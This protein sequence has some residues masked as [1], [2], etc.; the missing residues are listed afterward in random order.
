MKC[1]KESFKY[2]FGR[3]FFGTVGI[4]CNF[5]GVDHLNIADASMLNKLSPFFAIIFSFFILKE[6]V[7]NY[8]IGC[9]L[10]AIIGA[11]FILKPSGSAMLSVPA[12]IAMVG[13]MGAG[14]A[15]TLLRK[16]TGM[17][18]KGPFIVFFFSVFSCLC[19]LPYCIFNYTHMEPIQCFYLFMTGVAATFGQFF[20]TAA[21]SHAPAKELSVYDYSNVIFAG[22]LGFIILGE[23]PDVFS[24]IGC[25]LIISP[26]VIMFIVG[27]KRELKEA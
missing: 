21:Y 2:V 19:S 18:V 14:M 23:V 22:I 6:K 4:F 12:L 25:V 15:Y 13:G 26:A 5:Y 16:A 10:T 8:Q 3:A 9:L 1:S 27:N 17:G 11:M 20:I 24:Y 7:A